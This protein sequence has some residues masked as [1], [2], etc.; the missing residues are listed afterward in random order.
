MLISGRCFI[1][2]KSWKELN[3][4]KDYEQIHLKKMQ[5]GV[6]FSQRKEKLFWATGTEMENWKPKP[7][8]G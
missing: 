4:V 7:G 6:I 3:P 1:W 8:V 5:L 2:T